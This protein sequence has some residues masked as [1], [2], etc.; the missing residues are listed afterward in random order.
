MSVLVT[1]SLAFDH[2][3]RFP[4]YFK[5]N[6]LPD[7]I[8]MFNVSFV[9]SSL[10]RQRGGTGG[11][12]AYSLAL[13]GETPRLFAS[14][15]HDSTAYLEE[16]RAIGV[17]T[18]AVDVVEDFTA[19]AFIM[20]DN[21]NNQITGFYP[22]A[23]NHAG[24]RSLRE[25]VAPG[26]TLALVSANSLSAVRR[27]TAECRELGIPYIHD[28]GMSLP[29][30]TDED[31]VEGITGAEVVIGNDYEMALIAERT[32]FDRD[33]LRR[34]ARIIV[35]TLG[36]QG[37]EI[38]FQG[39][40]HRI[41]VAVAD[42]M[43]DPTGAGDAYRSG[44]VLGLTRGFPLPIAGRIASLAATYAVEHLG[45]QAHSYT[46]AEFAERFNRT[47]PDVSPLTASLSVERGV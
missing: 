2:I 15:G 8:H 10:T 36:D 23:M 28:L 32:G 45:T 18:S 29:I 19:S 26:T 25:V 17:D 44:L 43:I 34:R 33:E 24:E 6:I 3:M 30:L 31:L 27:Y 41:P 35:T 12:I 13:L 21:S 38:D 7:K 40:V 46:T 42:P 4:G 47:F 1:G 11:N 20:T 39:E 14:S 16:L 37:S 5:D 9:V 22:G